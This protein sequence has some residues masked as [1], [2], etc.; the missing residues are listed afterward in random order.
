MPKKSCQFIN[1]DPLYKIGQ[2]FL[3]MQY[4]NTKQ[5]LWTMTFRDNNG[6]F[7]LILIVSSLLYNLRLKKTKHVCCNLLNNGNISKIFCFRNHQ[8]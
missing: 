3:D 4:R 6:N 2:E 1:C 5:T 7:S 8:S